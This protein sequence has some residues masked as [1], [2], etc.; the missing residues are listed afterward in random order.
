MIK[1]TRINGEPVVVNA[2]FIELVEPTPDTVISLTT[3]KKMM[4]QETVDQVIERIVEYRARIGAR[5]QPQTRS[6]AGDEDDA[7]AAVMPCG[8]CNGTK[9]QGR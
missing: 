6:R 8:G 7:A 5:T 4:V 9:S 3:G 1:V 2:D